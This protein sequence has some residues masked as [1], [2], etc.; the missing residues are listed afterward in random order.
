MILADR[1]MLCID[2]FDTM[3]DNDRAAIHEAMEQ[4]TVTI[5]KANV[6]ASL[7]A[8]CS[9]LATANSINGKYDS[10]RSVGYNTGLSEPLLSRFDLVFVMLDE[11]EPLNDLRIAERTIF[12]H[13]FAGI[14]PHIP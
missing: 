8:R 7:N 14:S 6:K 13:C 4:Q 10:T 5:F 9:V 3:D 1:G 11:K 2:E 12:S